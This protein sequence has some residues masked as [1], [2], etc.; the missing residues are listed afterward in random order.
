MREARTS[1]V[2]IGVAWIACAL[3]LAG[4]AQ[5]PAEV[6]APAETTPSAETA[7]ASASAPATAPTGA[8]EGAS[9]AAAESTGPAD[10]ASGARSNEDDGRHFAWVKR[11][12]RKDGH[13]WVQADFLQL[14]EG[15]AAW[16][17]A[18]KHSD[19]APNDYYILNENKK[20]REF[21]LRDT[22]EVRMDELDREAPF[23]HYTLSA[24]EFFSAWTEAAEDDYPRVYDYFLT[25]ENGE[26]VMM[27]NFWTP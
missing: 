17:E 18:A 1:R 20:L 4:C 10:T 7:V 11:V 5:R 15:D 13:V 9:V 2:G 23:D 21:P 12:Y 8:D 3:A 24:E 19:E 6:G 26:V 14:F 25:I 27:E 22:A 16:A